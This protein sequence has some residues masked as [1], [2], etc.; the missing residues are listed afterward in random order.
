MPCIQEDRLREMES[1]GIN[2]NMHL[3]VPLQSKVSYMVI[4]VRD[5]IFYVAD[6][7]TPCEE[8]FAIK[9]KNTL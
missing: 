7:P 6:G 9:T 3:K 4:I 2:T 1:C 5:G 8:L